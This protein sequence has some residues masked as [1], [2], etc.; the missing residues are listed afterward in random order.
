M[1]STTFSRRRRSVLATLLA[2]ALPAARQAEGQAE[3]SVRE[4]V[5]DITAASITV[6]QHPLVFARERTDLAVNAR[7]YITL[8]PL[9]IN[10]S[11]TRRYF[12][13]GYLWSTIDRREG[14][15]VVAAGDQLVL[16]ADGRP[17]LLAGDGRA[18]RDQGVGEPPIR[19]PVRSAKAVLFA[20][21]PETIAYAAHAAELRID[22]IHVGITESFVLWKDSRS[23]LREFA[24]RVGASK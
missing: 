12:W 4:Y 8:A 17:I 22:L 10:R 3:S 24:E 6:P 1:Q 2:L 16:L 11:G 18:L 7:D 13:S 20:A 19:V 23:E 5:D 9:E 21:D 14:E 15:P